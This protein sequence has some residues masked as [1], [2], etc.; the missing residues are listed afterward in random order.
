MCIACSDSSLYTFIVTVYLRPS[1]FTHEHEVV[2]VYRMLLI[3]CQ[4]LLDKKLSTLR[5]FHKKITA[6][7][8]S[9]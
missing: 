5:T 6:V 4:D 9:W 2:G 7:Q 3:A 1:I 8:F